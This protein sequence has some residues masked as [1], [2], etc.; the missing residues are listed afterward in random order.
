[1]TTEPI[2]HMRHWG[3]KYPIIQVKEG[4][5]GDAANTLIT[6]I[7]VRTKRDIVRYT[8]PGHVGDYYRVAEDVQQET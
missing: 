1:M 6:F 8:R 5:S 2:T 7:D 4:Y 3:R